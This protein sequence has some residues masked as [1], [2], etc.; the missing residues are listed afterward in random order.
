M[1]TT[2]VD[3]LTLGKLVWYILYTLIHN[4]FY[5]IN[6]EH[7]ISINYIASLV[8]LN[9]NRSTPKSKLDHDLS[10]DTGVCTVCPKT[11]VDTLNQ[12]TSNN[13][14]QFALDIVK[15]LSRH[16]FGRVNALGSSIRKPRIRPISHI[17]H[18][19]DVV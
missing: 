4:L 15:L 14:C 10:S 11:D 3:D 18:L 5:L 9:F 17:Q 16:Q 8:K 19:I 12:S 1:R 2:L 6:Y 7:W 13:F